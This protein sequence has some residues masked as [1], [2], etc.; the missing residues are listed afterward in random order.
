ML[1]AFFLYA[2]GPLFP[3]TNSRFLPWYLAGFGIGLFNL[4]SGLNL[5]QSTEAEFQAM[6]REGA[7]A[8]RPQLHSL[9]LLPSRDGR[10]QC[11]LPSRSI[12]WRCGL[13]A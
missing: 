3:A 13:R 9:L 7:A 10:P 11:E 12:F 5:V 4:L 2:P 6:C 1:I 8:P